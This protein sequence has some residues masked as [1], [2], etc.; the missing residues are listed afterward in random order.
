MN[1]MKL[2]YVNWKRNLEKVEVRCYSQAGEVG[3]VQMEKFPVS[4]HRYEILSH[5]FSFGQDRT[6]PQVSA[7]GEAH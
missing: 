1:D 3:Q 2:I 7:K 4:H 6:S 5:S